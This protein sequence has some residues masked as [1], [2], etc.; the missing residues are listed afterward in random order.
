[1]KGKGRNIKKEIKKINEEKTNR[2]SIFV[3]FKVLIF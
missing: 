3:L 2:F 1:V